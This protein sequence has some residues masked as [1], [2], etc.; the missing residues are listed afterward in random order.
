MTL[1]TYFHKIHRIDYLFY[2][3]GLKPLNYLCGDYL[4]SDHK[5]VIVE[6]EFEKEK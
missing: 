6:F 1:N 4:F 3:D 2:S 5:P